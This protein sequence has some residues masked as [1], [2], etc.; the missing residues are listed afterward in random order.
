MK[1][2]YSD[3]CHLLTEQFPRTGWASLDC[4]LFSRMPARI[5][6]QLM[7][8]ATGAPCTVCGVEVQFICVGLI[9]LRIERQCA[10][11][12]Q[13]TRLSSFLAHGLV[14]GQLAC[15]EGRE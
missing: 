8:A 7:G 2:C 14:D 3:P 1:Q 10:S 6:F 9:I 11:S 12:H 13:L 15:S 5:R 4:L